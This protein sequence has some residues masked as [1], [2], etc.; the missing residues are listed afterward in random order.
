MARSGEDVSD[1]FCADSNLPS[2]TVTCEVPCGMD[3]VVTEWSKWSPCSHSCS[4]K[5]AEGR[6]RRT[7]LILALP[8][9]GG[10]P[11][12]PS[13]A[14]QEYR[15]CNE[16]SCNVV[17]WE[18]SAWNPCSE[19]ILITALNATINWNAEA[20]CGV[21]M[22]TRKVFCMK[23][24]YGQI[25]AKRWKVHKWSPCI[26]VPDSIKQGILGANEACG[27]GL[28]SRAVTCVL[29]G[30]QT[31]DVSECLKW[32]EPMPSFVQECLIPCKDDCKFTPW[33]KFTSCASDCESTRTRRRT[34]TGRSRKQDKC[35]NTEVY[36]QVETERCPCAVFTTRPHGNWSECIIAAGNAE[37]QLE[38]RLHGHTKE[39][40]EG[41]RFQALA[42]YD[43]TGRLVES[44]HC[45]S[46]GYV[47]QPCVM[48]CPFDCKLSDWS[49][50]SPC[51]SSC[52][53]GVKIRS[54]WLKEK[55]Y[56]GG[57]PC[58]K[59]DPKNQV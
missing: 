26:L 47:E 56:N 55:P 6:Q 7:R 51:S 20:T 16:H 28:K 38:S 40:G 12:P 42:C 18:V 43:K 15:M 3:C 1:E 54:R 11:C 37:F 52:G 32:A 33:S 9:E 58:P 14:L 2:K 49:S 13:R 41:V 45:N 29:E 5:N 8:G 10:K 59:L 50:W 36:P 19:N 57:R 24:N 22:Q 21:G 44:S 31:V 4:S 23:S 17:Y 30:N 27:R 53:T 25:P 35:Q 39:C 46:S 34:L 48:P